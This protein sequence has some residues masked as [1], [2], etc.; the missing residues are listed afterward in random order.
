MLM[1]S[2]PS[3]EEDSPTRRFERS[4]LIWPSLYLKLQGVG[5]DGAVILQNKLLR[6]AVLSFPGKLKPRLIGMEA[7]TRFPRLASSM[8][9]RRE[10]FIAFVFTKHALL[11]IPSQCGRIFEQYAKSPTGA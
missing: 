9:A 5:A 11:T 2:Q 8:S 7:K 10:Q 6:G 4:G 1:L 3:R